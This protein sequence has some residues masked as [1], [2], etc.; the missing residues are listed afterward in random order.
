MNRDWSPL[1]G[2]GNNYR[3][4]KRDNVRNTNFSLSAE[5]PSLSPTVYWI[6][7][8]PLTGLTLR[9]IC[10]C[11][12]NYGTVVRR[13]SRTVD[14]VPARIPIHIVSSIKL[15]AFRINADFVHSK[16]FYFSRELFLPDKRNDYLLC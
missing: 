10:Q 16:Q 6:K 9:L 15:N 1:T 5:T 12:R 13:H 7:L 14:D 4:L 8:Y 3:R 2:E 11:H